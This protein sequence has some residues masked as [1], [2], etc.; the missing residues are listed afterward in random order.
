MLIKQ[1]AFY[2]GIGCAKYGNGKNIQ[3]KKEKEVKRYALSVNKRFN[4]KKIQ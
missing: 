3:A 2:P 4:N 1:I